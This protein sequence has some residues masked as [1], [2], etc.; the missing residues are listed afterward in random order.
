[1]K[2]VNHI[3]VF[4]FS[5]LGDVAMTV[6]VLKNLLEQHP[7]LHITVVSRPF[8]EPMFQQIDRL[9]FF[10]AELKKE[11][12]GLTGLIKL[13]RRIKKE[14]TYDAIADLH[15]SLRT[16][17]LRSLLPGASAVIDKGRKE[18]KELTRKKNKIIRPLRTTFQ[19]YADVFEKLGHPVKLDIQKG[20]V[21][22]KLKPELLPVK[23]EG[24][25]W[26]GYAPFAKHLPKLYPL[27]KSREVVQLLS[28]LNG[29]T[30]LL[31]GSEEE[32][33]ILNSWEKE[34]PNV[35]SVPGKYNFSDELNLVAQLNVMVSMDSAPMHLASLYGIPVVSVWGG[36]HTFA[37]FYGWGQ[38]LDYAVQLD[39]PCRPSS[40]FGNKKCPVHGEQGCMEG[41]E[42]GMI[43]DRVQK[44]IAQNSSNQIPNSK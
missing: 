14:I 26:I 31:F 22:P 44:V 11:F 30:I 39:L 40:V 28:Q 25:Q 24:T 34:I 27:E 4:R 20:I 19:R 42:P 18:K 29:T 5:A 9:D 15:D 23:K 6:P 36:T 38:S 10:P 21:H 37:G 8:F 16:K 33:S 35:Y 2:Q 17:T 7:A 3:L 41:I 12:S 43:I 13:S 32:G 1:M